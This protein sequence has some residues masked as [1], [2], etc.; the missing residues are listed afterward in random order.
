MLKLQRLFHGLREY[1]SE[2][3]G[4]KA[5]DR[6]CAFT[7]AHGERPMSAQDFYLWQQREKYSRPSRCC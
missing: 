2:V 1:L 4:E 5:Y 3:L 6:Y 7:L